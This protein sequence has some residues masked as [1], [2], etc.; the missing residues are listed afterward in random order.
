M[1]RICNWRGASL[2]V[3]AALLTTAAAPSAWAQPQAAEAAERDS[4]ALDEVVV[5]ARKREESLQDV[6]V[7]V[8]ALTTEQIAQRQVQS[9]DD[10]A[11]FTPGLV[12]SK[13]F[14]RATERPVMRGLAS[15]LAGTNP[16]VET[17]VAYF[18]DGIYYPS[19]IQSLDLNDVER[20]E[21]IRGPQSAL[22][23][24]N[25]YSGAVNFVTRGPSETLEG[26]VAANAD[27]DERQISA[28]LSGPLFGERLFGSLAA[29]FYDFDGQWKNLA[30]GRTVGDEQTKSLDGV[31]RL[32]PS[33]NTELRL[34]VQWTEDRDGTRPLF[35]QSAE[36]NNCFP[37][38]RSLDSYNS[39]AS[40]NRNQYYCGSIE[41]RPIYLNDAPVTQSVPIVPGIPATLNPAPNV[42]TGGIYDTR[43][44]VAFSGVERDLALASVVFKWDIAG[45]GYRLTVDGSIRSEDRWTGADSD[46][47]QVN[48]IGPAVNGVQ[49][50]AVGAGTD[51]DEFRDWSFEAKIESPADRSFR[52]LL[53]AYHFEFQR[54]QFGLDFLSPRGQDN[55]SQISDIT[56]NAVFGSIEYDFTERWSATAELRRAKEWKGQTDWAAVTNVQ[57]GPT[58]APT[59][60][61]K[62]SWTSTTPRVTVTFK[63]SDDLTLYANYAQGFKPGG[64]NGATA[65]L[66]GRP[67]DVF[68]DQEESRNYEL[69]LKSAWLDRRLLVNLALFRIDVDDMQLTTPIVNAMGAVTS[70]ST[71]Q[72]SGKINGAELETRWRATEYLTLGFN[73]ALADSEF[74]EGCDD[75]QFQITSG[76]GVF[77]PANPTDP[78]RNLN[79]RGTCSIVGNAFPL[80]A[81][82]TASLTADFR[83]P[84]FDGRFEFYANGDVSY[85]SKKFVQVHNL[86]YTP[87]ATLVGARF[88]FE[89]E[90]WRIGIY[91]RNLTDEDASPSATRW[92]HPYLIGIP[93]LTLDPGLPPTTIASYSLPRGFFGILRRERQIGLEASYRF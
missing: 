89:T 45:S 28:R 61:Q 67:Q 46:H 57:S 4:L 52:W 68:F 43:Q 63:A 29:R 21:V 9:I 60:S 22:Y 33:D 72:G 65:L 92:L 66:N 90:Q 79:G 40:T 47:S 74:T 32:V 26:A 78:T 15:V 71:N 82:H 55:P 39:T 37:G 34:R 18:V 50:E 91:G 80:A 58:T 76:G 44:G 41:P 12:F 14:G 51:Y 88:G 62:G 8:T 38:T 53:G 77:N 35:F 59:F 64:L 2:S 6:P 25:T 93:G 48:I 19:D 84:V 24:R 69:G 27:S 81:K 13:A 85:T 42:A 3:A 16:T 23:G 87:A 83:R 20:I 75:F 7:A 31:L 86:A 17:G 10:V 70:L 11:K 30:T 54:D 36:F 5:T 73:Y 49:R 1:S 56:N